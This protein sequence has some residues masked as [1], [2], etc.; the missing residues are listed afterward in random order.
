MDVIQKL[1]FTPIL[2]LNSQNNCNISAPLIQEMTYQRLT[3]MEGPVKFEFIFQD[4]LITEIYSEKT[5][6]FYPNSVKYVKC[7]P[8]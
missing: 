3:G 1:S 4:N 6:L 8:F 2:L 5:S 7:I